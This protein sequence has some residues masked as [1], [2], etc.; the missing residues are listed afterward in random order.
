MT[1]A[2]RQWR[3]RLSVPAYRVADAARYA[4]TTTQ[5]VNNWQRAVISDREAGKALSYL[6]LVELGVVAA[7]RKQG[8]TLKTIRKTR[9]Y[10]AEEFGSQFPF[11]EYRFKTDGR[12]LM[13]DSEVLAPE[14]RNKLIVVSENGQFA[15]KEV[16]AKLLRQF[17]Y[18]DED[19]GIVVRWKLD[20]DDSPIIIDPRICFGEPQVGGVPTWTI[21]ERWV[22][23]EGLKDIATDYDIEPHLVSSALKFEGIPIDLKR[24]NTWAN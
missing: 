4:G 14:V 1:V 11:A 23:G 18:S 22:S 10:L 12:E 24:P 2:T 6:Q 16:L 21:R 5:T 19:D 17:E 7:M 8:V 20:G 15:W 3:E 13:M 9:L